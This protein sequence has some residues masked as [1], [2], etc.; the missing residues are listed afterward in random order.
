[1]QAGPSGPTVLF[2]L[3]RSAPWRLRFPDPAVER[4]FRHQFVRG[5]RAQVH[6]SGVSAAVVWSAF[7][8]LDLFVTEASQAMLTV[9]GTVLVALVVALVLSLRLPDPVLDR[10]QTALVCGS[11]LVV[12]TGLAVMPH[13][14]P[15]PGAYSTSGTLLTLLVLFCFAGVRTEPAAWTAG[16]VVLEHEVS[17]LA[18]DLS[19]YDVTNNNFFLLG[20]VVIG[21][22]ACR[23]IEQLRRQ[24]FLYDEALRGAFGRFVSPDLVEQVVQD[25]G[26]LPGHEVE[27]TVL[28]M[29]MRGFTRRAAEVG[30]RAAVELLNELFQVVLPVIRH[31]G[32]H[33]N[34]LLGD[35]VLAAFGAPSP[36]PDHADRALAAAL[37]VVAAVEERFHGEVRVGVGLSSGV[38]MAGTVGDAGKLDYALI[39]D[40]TNVATRVEALTKETG[41]LV[42]L[43]DA[44]RSR[45]QGDWP[46]VARGLHEVRGRPQGVVL[47][48]AV[49]APAQRGG[50]PAG[51]QRVTDSG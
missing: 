26:H 35:G 39:G 23:W 16:L 2:V 29:D 48:A 20:F 28:V 30:P 14:A 40:V 5:S 21:L 27:V 43:T 8:I 44:V 33:V 46:L 31:Q 12:S 18:G 41:D 13:V 15:L 6:A 47:H 22:G 38:V 17:L 25:G 42:L 4:A 51:A 11:I 50:A 3:D 7:G 19:G 45:L 34:A 49:T 32:G 37:G 10:V 36:L 1:V 9:R 24:Q